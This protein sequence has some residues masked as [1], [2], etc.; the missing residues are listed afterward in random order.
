MSSP[1]ALLD[2]GP[3]V[4]YLSPHDSHHAWAR[5]SL[6]RLRPPLFTTEPVLTEACFLLS[7]TAH[8]V[9][10]V[11]E[12]LARDTLAV[13]L[14]VTEEAGALRRLISKYANVPMSLA[15]ASLVR[16]S[17]LSGS[18]PVL[19]LDSDFRRYRRHGR[20]AISLISPFGR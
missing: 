3:L 17:E 11:F 5:E 18:A 20:Q 6:F 8:G 4:A 10:L 19:T 14:S 13:G 15:D 7:R 16:L 1:S 9:D 12:M 2:T